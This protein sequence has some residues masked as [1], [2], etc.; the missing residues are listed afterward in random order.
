[1][2][3]PSNKIN[4]QRWYT[5]PLN[6]GEKNQVQ[7]LFKLV[8]NS[9]LNDLFFT[10]KYANEHGYAVG[11]FNHN[12]ELVG[13]YAGFRRQ[14]SYFGVKKQVLQIGDVMVHPSERAIFT[15][16]GVFFLAASYFFE[17]YIGDNK[18]F[19]LAFGF[20]NQRA[21]SIGKRLNLYAQV[22]KISICQWF[23]KTNF[24]GKIFQLSPVT[25]IEKNIVDSLW[26][27]MEASLKNYICTWRDNEYINYRYINRPEGDYR[28][29]IIKNYFTRKIISIV[30]LKC[31]Q[32]EMKIQWLDY[33]GP[34]KYIKKTIS[35][36]Q[37]YGK[38]N[39]FN[40]FESWVT[41]CMKPNFLTK[42]SN[43][44][45][46]DIEIAQSNWKDSRNLHQKTN[47]HWWLMYGDT[48][49]L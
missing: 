22:E 11:V 5:C 18:P 7:K 34:L 6:M 33:I 25:S 37:Y 12:H 17:H 41:E 42:D 23:C 26:K 1:M 28:L 8:F 49:F 29:F 39:G 30:V 2:T 47:Q 48:D 44:H 4:G 13:H 35:A 45:K 3:Q 36:I 10:W 31:F 15:R 14:V 27:N 32:S 19:L 20:P 24:I 46:T 43:V 21:M 9:D 38:I 40:Y 16:K